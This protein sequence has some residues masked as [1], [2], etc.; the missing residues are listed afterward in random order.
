M[1]TNKKA[2]PDCSR[3]TG[4]LDVTHNA[5][6][7]PI[8]SRLLVRTAIKQFIVRMALWGVIPVAVAEWLI[9]VTDFAKLWG[10]RELK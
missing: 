3:E 4:L 10:K 5:N 7:A 6:Y 2:R 9:K 8:V 1:T